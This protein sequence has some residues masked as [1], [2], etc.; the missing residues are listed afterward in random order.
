MMFDC[1]IVGGGPAG[2]TCSI[3]LARFKR[4]VLLIENGKYRNY[5]S[6]GIHGFLGYDGIKPSELLRKGKTEAL[7]YKVKFKKETVKKVV[8]K[9]EYFEVLA[10]GKIYR[11]KKVVLAYGVTDKIPSIKNFEKY[12]GRNIFHCPVCDG[13][14]ASGKIVGVIGQIDKVYE[15][16]VELKQWAN[17]IM[18]F[19]NGH[20]EGLDRYKINKLGKFNIRVTNEKILRLEG[21]N[22]LESIVLE[23]GERFRINILF[24]SNKIENS[25]ALAEDLK[26][27]L[28]KNHNRLVVNK[29]CESNIKGVFGIGDL[30]QGHQLVVTACSEGAVAA[31]EINRQLLKEYFKLKAGS[32]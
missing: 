13:Y 17:K 31:I 30:V 1:I 24:F 15:M 6:S 11:S 27:L 5:A 14:E 19:T 25:C 20:S 28:S 2:L 29:Y 12:Y 23:N 10:D 22:N 32:I 8:N 4:S 26:C 3:Y 9:N 7:K 21:N 16:A 18:V